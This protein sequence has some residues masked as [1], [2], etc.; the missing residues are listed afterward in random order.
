MTQRVALVT[1]ASSGIGRATAKLLAKNGY[2]VFAMARRMHR[3]EQIRSANIE[4]IC[5]DV[6]DANAIRVAV[7]HAMASKDRIDLL[8]NNAGYGQLGAIECVSMEAAHHQFEVNVFG[9][10]RFIQAVVPHMRA[11]K[12]G[13][14]INITSILG[15]IS[16]PGFGWYAASKHAVEALS[17][18]LRGEVMKFGINVVLIAPGL[19]KTEFAAKEFELL[20]TVA[21]PSVYQK[22]LT[23]LPRLLAGEPQA[24]GPE[25]IAKAV[26]NAATASFPPMRHELP[27]DSK[28]AVVSRWLL[29]GRIFDRAVRLKMKI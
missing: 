7:S 21:H 8:V 19:I 27:A 23:A 4:P 22:L 29:G 24:P 16:I 2:Y 10:A 25:I 11:Q 3:L 5:L 12:S 9:Y 17:E 18:T 20:K 26:L 13:C 1:G 15:K 6:T 28:I 14:I